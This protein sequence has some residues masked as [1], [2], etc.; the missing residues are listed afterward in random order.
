MASHVTRL[1]HIRLWLLALLLLFRLL[2]LPELH[3]LLLLPVLLLLM[4]L[5]LR[6]LLVTSRIARVVHIL[7]PLALLLRLLG[8]GLSVDGLR[9]EEGC[10]ARREADAEGTLHVV[11]FILNLLPVGDNLVVRALVVGLGAL[12]VSLQEGVELLEREV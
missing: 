4:R 9:S 1:V 5:H 2:L 6:L 12:L 10:G 11:Q 8:L 3:L 7:L